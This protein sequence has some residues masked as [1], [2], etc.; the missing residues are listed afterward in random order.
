MHAIAAHASPAAVIEAACAG[1]LHAARAPILGLQRLEL[2]E[3]ETLTLPPLFHLLR[4]G[5]HS[6]PGVMAGTAGLRAAREVRPVRSRE[7]IGAPPNFSERG[8][9][10][11]VTREG[12]PQ[13]GEGLLH[14]G[15]GAVHVDQLGAEGHEVRVVLVDHLHQLRPP[16]PH[17]SPLAA[18]IS[19]A[20]T[21][22]PSH[23]GWPVA[24]RQTRRQRET[25]LVKRETGKEEMV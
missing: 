24:D 13:V 7:D 21:L 23:A 4:L 6:P 19:C 11:S 9:M 3:F 16:P 8:S 2:G 22:L 12:Y 17:R 14:A 15:D 20:A 10:F 25:R 18:V 1:N 5:R